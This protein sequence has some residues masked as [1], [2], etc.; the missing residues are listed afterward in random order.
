MTIDTFR[1]AYLAKYDGTNLERAVGSAIELAE[2]LVTGDWGMMASLRPV[3]FEQA[4]EA[5]VTYLLETSNSSKQ[6]LLRDYEN[7]YKVARDRLASDFYDH[8][9][10]SDKDGKPK[11]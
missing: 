8:Y 4:K 2:E 11:R 3:E 7:I 6:T 5:F 9:V 10:M 1:E